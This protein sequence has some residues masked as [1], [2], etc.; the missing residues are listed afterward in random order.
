MKAQHEVAGNHGSGLERP[1]TPEAQTGKGPKTPKTPKSPMDDNVLPANETTPRP[2]KAK[3]HPVRAKNIPKQSPAK[4]KRANAEKVAEK[5]VLPTKWS[6]A[7][8]ADKTLVAMKEDGHPWSEIRVKWHEMTGQ[9][10]APS[11]LPNR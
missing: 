10:T 5:V 3:A 8:Q 4:G 6:E 7:S 2:A 1:S 11:T 9:D